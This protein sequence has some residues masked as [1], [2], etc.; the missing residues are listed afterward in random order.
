MGRVVVLGGA[1]GVGSVAVEALTHLEEAEEIVVADVS[2]NA[3]RELVDRLGS[4]PRLRAASVDVMD[5][6]GLGGLIRDA[7]VVLNCVGPFYRY[8]PPALRAAIG[9]GV[10]YVDVCD[11]LDA[12][13]ALLGMDAAAREAGVTALIGMGNSPGLANVFVRLCADDLLDEVTAVDIFHIHGGEPSEG[14]A[15]LK[16]RVHAMVNDVPL[17]V[18]GE[19][20]AVRQLEA[21]GAAHVR[22]VDFAG[23]GTYPVYPYPHPETITL[24]AT[25]PGLRRATNLG[26]VYPL[27][28]FEMT[29]DLVRAGM[30]GEEPIPVGD[31]EVAP[32]DVM[33]ALLQHERPRLLAEDGVSEPGGCLRVDVAGTRDGEEHRYVCSLTSAGSGAGEGTGIPAALGA[34]LHLRGSL[35]D[36]PG[37]HPPEAIVDAGEILDLA[38]RVVNRMSIGS[39][40]GVPL[41]VEHIAPDGTCEPIP[42]TIG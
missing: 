35:G 38:G 28:Y 33:V 3:A 13:R 19:F 7:D 15:V 23:V 25:F 41:T 32:I 12:T 26:V 36:R 22:Q 17:F 2:E 5:P 27:S 6:D 34:A 39:G 1:G 8:G 4:D 11:D 16:H 14:A 10:G 40:G 29:Q 31:L 30:A 42:L 24:P 20:I 18:D 21:S 9:A 37:V